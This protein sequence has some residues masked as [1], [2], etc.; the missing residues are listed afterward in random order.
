MEVAVLTIKVTI[1]SAKSVP[2]VVSRSMASARVPRSQSSTP[3]P[4]ESLIEVI[5]LFSAVR[6]VLMLSVTRSPELFTNRDTWPNPMVSSQVSRP[7]PMHSRSST[8]TNDAAPR[9]SFS[10]FSRKRIT[11]CRAA[12]SGIAI[13][14]GDSLSQISGRTQITKAAVSRK[15]SR[16]SARRSAAFLSS[17]IRAP[18]FPVPLFVLNIYFTAVWLHLQ[19]LLVRRS[20]PPRPP[21]WIPRPRAAGYSLPAAGPSPSGPGFGD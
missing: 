20:V 6:T 14:N 19:P 3:G 4:V 15:P 2:Q 17:L 10:F 9:R 7:R 16:R 11:G 5:R 18:S 1:S 13:M 8:G 21:R 12:A